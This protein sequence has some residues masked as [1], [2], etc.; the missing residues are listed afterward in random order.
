M[1]PLMTQC[2][3]C[4]IEKRKVPDPLSKVW[5]YLDETGRLWNGAL[6]PDCNNMK[7]RKRRAAILGREF[8]KDV[9]YYGRPI[10]RGRRRAECGGLSNLFGTTLPESSIDLS[11]TE[12]LQWGYGNLDGSSGANS[13]EQS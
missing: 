4:K 1:R 7:S 8:A 12:D 11:T 3:E 5:R 6:C 2:K 9:D 13:P 10:K